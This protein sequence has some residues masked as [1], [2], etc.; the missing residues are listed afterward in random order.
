MESD[1][2]RIWNALEGA[3]MDD[4]NR[5][6]TYHNLECARLRGGRC[7]CK[8]AVTFTPPRHYTPIDGINYSYP[9]STRGWREEITLDGQFIQVFDN[10]GDLIDESPNPEF[11]NLEFE[12]PYED[13]SEATDE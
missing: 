10:Q 2:Q 12:P 9:E 6:R 13:D 5:P 1:H 4:E 11:E 3:P 7:D 8:M